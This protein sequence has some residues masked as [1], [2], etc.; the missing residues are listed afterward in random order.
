MP[1]T[2][3]DIF[4][5][6]PDVEVIEVLGY[7]DGESFGLSPD[8]RKLKLYDLN[9]ARQLAELP[10]S[11]TETGHITDDGYYIRGGYSIREGAPKA[12]V[13]RLPPEQR[14]VK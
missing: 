11:N 5:D 8:G 6:Y 1:R 7:D 4:N 3:T 10:G 14:T 9:F 13:Y 2:L 12:F